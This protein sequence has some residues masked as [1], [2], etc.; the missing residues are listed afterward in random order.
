M[1]IAAIL[2]GAALAAS[3]SNAAPKPAAPAPIIPDAAVAVAPDAAPPIV[4]APAPTLRLPAVLHARGYTARLRIDPDQARFDG[5]ITIAATLD[6]PQTTLWLDSEGLTIDAAD[7]RYILPDPPGPSHDIP[8]FQQDTA[9]AAQVGRQFL[10]LHLPRTVRGGVTIHLTYHGTLEENSSAGAFRQKTNGDW[11]VVSQFE[12]MYARRVFPS[13][14]EPGSKVP[15]QLTIEAPGK[16]TVL[17]NTGV[18]RED[19]LAGGWVAHVFARTPPLPSYL[20]AFAV[21]PYELV[22][23]GVTRGGA[24][25]RIAA[26]RGRKQDAAYAAEV[27]P[28]VVAFLE[29]WFG[30]P[31][32]Y[33]KLDCVPIPLTVTFGAMENAGMITF[34]ETRL[35]FDAKDPS[36][37]KRRS[38]LGLAAHEI[39]HQWFGDYVTPAWWDDI[40]LNE[41]FATWMSPKVIATLQP[42]WRADLDAIAIDTSALDADAMTSARMIRQPIATEHDVEAAFDGITYQKGAAVIRMFEAWVGEA[43]FQ[44][45]VRAYMKAHGNGNATAKDFLDAIGAAAGKDVATPFDTLLEQ[46]G[47]PRI[48]ASLRCA[49]GKQPLVRLH[50][51]RYLPRGS[52]DD[53]PRRWQLPVCVAF[54][55]QG[56]RAETCTLLTDADGEVPLDTGACP[57][58]MYPNAGGGG[59]YHVALNATDR[60]ALVKQLG[61]LTLAERVTFA[62][63]VRAMIDHGD[64]ELTTA[65]ALIPPLVRGGSR[66]EIEAAIGLAGIAGGFLTD[67]QRTT[68][69]AWLVREFGPLARKLGWRPKKPGDLEAERLRAALVPMV[70]DAGDRELTTEAIKLAK[71]W[72]A[73]PAALRA[74]VLPI[75]AQDPSI[76]AAL[77]RDLFAE[78]DRS[79]RA[80]LMTALAGV[81][82]LPLEA[83]SLALMLDKRLDKRETRL[84][85]GMVRGE[86]PNITLAAR[87]LRDHFADIVLAA[88][89]EARARFVPVV[90][91]VCD[92]VTRDEVARYATETFAAFPAGP[93]RVAQAIEAMDQC[94]ARRA[95]LAPAQAKRFGP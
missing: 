92:P 48:T 63:D 56:R 58:W 60:N 3:C 26:L 80:D 1:R 44:D 7:V 14:D 45:G 16:Q 91:R 6:D 85:A 70:A 51:D 39:A 42:T 52:T 57:A 12:S 77:T 21:G 36:W 71:S 94:I 88:P 76:Y 32:P 8:N 25:I 61:S 74:M 28:K 43:R 62:R 55:R 19:K 13:I 54:E 67:H 2:A 40:W 81:Q 66:A 47:A 34:A 29:D 17:S 15:W 59:Y 82:A 84:I 37:A 20:I 69:R 53:G 78:T 83:K 18:E 46:S 27:T 5:E 68:Y 86:V 64:A 31:Y 9:T 87:F 23:A 89:E 10:A 11:Y 4:D 93:R 65:L 72:R 30:M 22:D 95:A 79:R 38:Y 33:D 41:A 24:P 50:Q 49:G 35:L 90:T 73:L 75:A